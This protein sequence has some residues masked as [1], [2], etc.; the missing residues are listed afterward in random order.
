MVC[1]QLDQLG[2]FLRQLLIKLRICRRIIGIQLTLQFRNFLLQLR[3]LRFQ[4]GKLLSHI[5]QFFQ[6]IQL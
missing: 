5:F 6:G 1:L 3:D 2:I 4:L